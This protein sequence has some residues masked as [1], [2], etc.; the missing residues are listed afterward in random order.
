MA[1]AD[2]YVVDF[3]QRFGIEDTHNIFTFERGEGGSP[4]GLADAFITTLVPPI[5]NMQSSV[6][7]NVSVRVYGLTE[8]AP[9]WEQDVAGQG[10]IADAEILPLHDAANFTMKVGTRAVRPG[11]KRI[12]GIPE[13]GQVNG[14]FETVGYLNLLN[15]VRLALAA[16]VSAEAEVDYT[17]VV[18]K[19]IKYAVPDSDPVRYAYR[20]PTEGDPLVYAPVAACLLN[21]KVS[22]QTSR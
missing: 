12:S 4:F 1:L 5:N 16:P 8:D 20:F 18:V 15:L 9:L 17:P 3:K 19:R 21:R 11:S 14:M 13:A 7:A 10:T 2:I 22:H 6:I